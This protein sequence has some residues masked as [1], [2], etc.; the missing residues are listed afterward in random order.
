VP[1]PATL[2]AKLRA[3]AGKRPADQPLLLKTD[4]TAWHQIRPDDHLEP[5]A[6]AAARAGLAGV[7]M[8]ALRHSAIVRSLIAGVPIR[9]VAANVDTSTVEI[10][11]TY[12][13]YLGD[14]ADEIARRALLDAGAPSSNVIPIAGWRSC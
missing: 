14:H 13:K 7:T 8:Y 12:S 4:G 9:I 6:Q 3:A 5:F 11:R 1:I 2:A 10:E